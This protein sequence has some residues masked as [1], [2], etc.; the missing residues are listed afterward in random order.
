MGEKMLISNKSN[1]LSVLLYCIL[2]IILLS[3]GTETTSSKNDI[4]GTVHPDGNGL[5]MTFASP[6]DLA[7]ALIGGHTLQAEATV[8][9]ETYP[10]DVN[11]D[12]NEISGTIPDISVGTHAIQVTYFISTTEKITLCTFSKNVTVTAGQQSEVIIGDSDLNRNY[13]DDNDKYINLEEI[14]NNT[15][16]L[17]PDDHPVTPPG[18]P[19]NVIAIAGNNMVTLEWESV[20]NASEYIIYMGTS[21]GVSKN[22]NVFSGTCSETFCNIDELTNGVLYYFVVT[23][24][25]VNGESNESEEV[26]ATPQPCNDGDTRPCGSDIGECVSGS[27]LC[28]NG[29]WSGI[30][31]GETGPIAE[32]CDGLDNDCNGKIDDNLS[33][34]STCGKGVCAGNTGTETCING[35]WG[36]NTCDPFAGAGVEVC[37]ETLDENCDGTVDEGC[38]CTSGTTR[39]CGTDTGECVSGTETCT[40]GQ[41]SGVC[42]GEVVQTDEICDKLDNDCD[43]NIDNG[44]CNPGESCG[45]DGII[46]CNQI[47]A[48]AWWLG[49]G[50][51]DSDPDVADFRC[52]NNDEGDCVPD[53]GDSCG[54]GMIYDCIGNCEPASYLGDT[55]CDDDTSDTDPDAADFTCINNDEGDCLLF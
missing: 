15:D 10:L 21:S 42:V 44:V 25:N 6:G 22:N 48:P 47:C 45:I 27:E 8:N 34:E 7:N 43:G 51:C 16:P 41:W 4:H 3:C 52:I 40:N 1:K 12:T 26:K 5:A 18:P 19:S 30:C 37:E 2:T 38:D 49:D 53:P 55:I 24:V 20:T 54:S 32:D 36:D 29:Q 13:D 50:S 17:D 31:K 28:S 11:P 9:G 35:V 14:K 33:R 46:D 23:S 39:T